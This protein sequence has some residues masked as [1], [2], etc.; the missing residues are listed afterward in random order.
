MTK[1]NEDE[2]NKVI[3][4]NSIL[5]VCFKGAEY[6]LSFFTAPL[7][8]Q[9]LGVSK[10]GVYTSA[11]SIISWIYYFDFGIGNG[12]RNKVAE[13]IVKKDY[14]TAKNST[15]VAY[16]IVSIVSIIAFCTV[17]IFSYFVNID[18]LLNAN[19]TDENLNFIMIIAFL[20]A[21]INFVLTLATNMLYAIKQTAMVSGLGIVSKVLMVVALFLFARFKITAML[22]LVVLEGVVQL[23]KNILAT[24]LVIRK[25][26]SLCP[27][28][29]NI[30]FKYSKGLL[31]FG[32]QIFIMQI[33]ALVL[34]ATDN[35]III[36][37]FGSEDVTPYSMCHKYFSII[38]AFFVA[39]TSPLWT[40]Y[41][42][43][44]ALND[45]GYIKKT[46]KKALKFYLLTFT[47]IV[48]SVFVFKPFMKLYLGQ[49]LEYQSGLI[50]CVAFYY[51]LL[52]FSHNFSAFVHGI[53][54]VK[55]TTIACTVS[56]IVNV[57]VSIVLA[58][59]FHLGLNGVMLGSIV[60][61]VITTTVYIYTTIKEINKMKE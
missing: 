28:F 11:L 16:V 34:N 5:S 15:T 48:A 42:T 40:V 38:N 22:Y 54:K 6:L 20:L 47:G 18:K 33:S 13:A 36:K 17:F 60:G 21:C 24:V 57:P 55:Y 37:L 4:K 12:L 53:S 58:K 27:D 8:L 7:M 44:Y 26:R 61:L 49:E 2:E 39:A 45:V 14:E 43:A 29:G 35:I 31:G 19:L 3:I 9:C 50:I 25:E 1:I 23:I 56:A 32:L 51:A 10:Y 52:I 59:N 46:L 41:T 30:D